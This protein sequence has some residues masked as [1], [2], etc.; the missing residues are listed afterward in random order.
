MMDGIISRNSADIELGSMI[1]S[2]SLVGDTMLLSNGAG[3]WMTSEVA[4]LFNSSGFSTVFVV[5]E[6]SFV[7]SVTV[8][9]T[10]VGDELVC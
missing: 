6:L 1:V 3:L 7:M 5:T 10:F 2:K 9:A 8:A 4:P